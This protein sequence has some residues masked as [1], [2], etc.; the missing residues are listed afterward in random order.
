VN[1]IKR[2]CKI[3]KEIEHFAQKIRRC[4][5]F[6]RDYREILK[7]P[8]VDNPRAAIYLDPPYIGVEK[9]YYG[10]NKREGFDHRAMRDAIE[11]CR[12]SVVVSYGEDERIRDL[13]LREDGWRIESK[14]TTCSLGNNDKQAEELLLV[15]VSDWAKS[16]AGARPRRMKA[17]DL[18][19]RTI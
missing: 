18:F 7:L 15:R 17:V 19:P 5:L 12:A 13:Y 6:C 8:E 2:W 11:S 14:S 4:H 1:T 3:E 16:R 10:P 9:L